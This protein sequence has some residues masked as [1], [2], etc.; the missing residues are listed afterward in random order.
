MISNKKAVLTSLL[1]GTMAMGLSSATFAAD[2]PAGVKLAKVQE[3]VR[4][5]GSEPQTL[6]PQKLQGNPGSNVA[7]DLFEGLV[8]PGPQGQI[9]PGVAKSWETKDNKTFIFHLRKDARWS[10]G[11]TV[12]ADDFVFAWRRLVNP[13]TGANYA[14]Y[15]GLAGVKNAD[16]I[17]DG[18][19]KPDTLGVSAP[20]PH[21]LRVV[22]E[23]PVPYFV[24]MLTYPALSPT[25]AKV[26][27]KWG[28]KWTRPEHIVSNGAYKLKGWVVNGHID[29]VRNPDYWNNKKTVIN[30][31]RFL[32]IADPNAALNRYM[33][34][35]LDMTYTVP[36]EQFH[37][38]KKEYPNQ[39]KV[40]GQIATYYYAFNTKK[41]PF[42]DA[43]VRKALSY[44]IDRNAITKYILGQGQ[45]PAYTFTPDMTEGFTP[46]KLKWADWT[47]AERNKKAQQLLKE[48]GYDKQHP[49]TLTILYNTSDN[50]K[51]IAI[52]IASMWKQTLGV[53]AKLENQ[54]WKTFLQTRQQG[55]YEVAREGWIA[56]Y[57]E[58]SAM[59]SQLQCGIGTNDTGFCDSNYDKVMHEAAASTNAQQRSKFYDMA[60][61]IIAKEMPIAP[62][63]Q[64]VV[65]RMVKPYVGGYPHNP[66]D[67]ILD[68]DLYIKAH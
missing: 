33:A 23:K 3:M 46:P 60:E 41:K 65:P 66:M 62:V 35:E 63:Y 61:Q 67:N 10:N 56:D 47:Q 16:A 2:V 28:D 13:A 25:P 42:D 37:K 7:L 48:A 9:L 55:G 43:R 31:V 12:T 57:N 21:T 5:N 26:I 19:K 24:N 53:N 51:K 45:L 18:K 54:E 39:L 58:P 1:A 52:A 11:E 44:A 15:L 49:L 4:N 17:S 20:D 34:G 29:L 68:K 59:L 6:D 32:P 27:K 22:L 40:V 64:Y 50:H 14:Y 38:L 8:T 36:L 30:K